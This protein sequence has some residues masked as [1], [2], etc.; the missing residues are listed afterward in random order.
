MSKQ[1][2][3]DSSEFLASTLC[4]LSLCFL[5]LRAHKLP[6]YLE[7]L[8]AE[9][10]AY[11]TAEHAQEGGFRMSGA[12]KALALNHVVEVEMVVVCIP[13]NVPKPGNNC[14]NEP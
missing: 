5:S 3:A 2:S 9:G 12:V 7:I 11:S 8:A 13:G 10:I 6:F 4:R 14:F 1:G